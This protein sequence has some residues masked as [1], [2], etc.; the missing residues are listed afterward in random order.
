MQIHL[1]YLHERRTV[2][3]EYLVELYDENKEKH[4]TYSQIIL[5]QDLIALL[6]NDRGQL[7]TPGKLT[8]EADY[9]TLI[10]GDRAWAAGDEDYGY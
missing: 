6:P 3:F 10:G 7:R 5:D 8:Q 9:Y 2:H 1:I 4:L